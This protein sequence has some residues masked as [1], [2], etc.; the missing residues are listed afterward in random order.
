[1]RAMMLTVMLPACLGSAVAAGE[2][3]E[4]PPGAF[5]PLD[6]GDHSEVA[7]FE[8]GQPL[9]GTTYFYWYDIESEA[10]IVNHDG[11]D[12][13]TTHPAE[14][15][16]ISYKRA[17][18]H[19]GQ[20]R[21]M[22]D[23]GIDFLMPVYWGVPGDYDGW[24]FVGLPPLVD[25]HAK[26]Q[27]EGAQPPA[28]GMFYD[29]SILQWNKFGQ[30][31]KAYHAD[32]TTEFGREW[33][34]TPVR[35]FY[36]MIPPAKW[37]RIDGR[38]I[39]F[40]YAAAFA[41]RQDRERQFEHVR[42]RFKEDFGVEP[43]LVKNADWQGEADAVY[44]WGGAVRG[45]ILFDQTIALGPGY[46]HTAVPGRTPLIVE[47][48]D[49]K[50]YVDRWTQVL[51]LD[52][53]RRPWLVHVETWNEWHEG[54]DVAA[55]REYG[56][57]YIVLTRLFADLWHAGTHLRLPSGYANARRVC[58]EP[59]RSAGL[60]LRPSGGD[61]NW[62]LREVEGA[63]AAVTLPNPHSAASRYLYFDADDAFAFNLLERNALL[64]VM[65]RDAGCSSFGVEYDST[66]AEGPFAGSFRPA[67]SRAVGDSAQWRTAEFRL[68]D[69]RFMNRANG[70]DL[71]LVV[72]G[73]DLD[74]AVRR[75]ELVSAD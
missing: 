61:G 16:G 4:E 15:E 7:S 24:S 69:C 18:W 72:T 58:W 26:L 9:V 47:R 38:P 40:L 65:Y 45:P 13:L 67:G 5:F 49:G 64:R 57:S 30:D 37:A 28:I 54:T 59:E 70:A 68:P 23:A 19:E 31:G 73:G 20:L 51:Q 52:P 17:A 22:I 10:H 11:S 1:M 33:F 35:D 2:L 60:D 44:S 66:V 75:V 36:S 14:M 12:A 50:T 71:R 62:E 27:R 74:L 56:R 6:V 32:L 42:R 8:R 39:V 53:K 46:D 3:P 34:Y 43:F 25:A 48:R 55:S 41:A 21:D 29:T 63:Q